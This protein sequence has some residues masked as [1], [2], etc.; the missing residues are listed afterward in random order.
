M[1]EDSGQA[2]A[3]EIEITS[4]MIAAGA[5]ALRECALG[6]SLENIALAV[7]S[8]AMAELHS[9]LPHQSM[10]TNRAGLS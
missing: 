7:I 10:M 2:G 4:E 8:S 5:Y 3:T 6:D 1:L 9:P